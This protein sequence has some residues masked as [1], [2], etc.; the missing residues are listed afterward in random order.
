MQLTSNLSFK[1]ILIKSVLK[2]SLLNSFLSPETESN[3]I[4][5][6]LVSEKRVKMNLLNVKRNCSTCFNA[7]KGSIIWPKKERKERKEK[8]NTIAALRSSRQQSLQ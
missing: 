6:I 3:S 8:K 7:I 4:A 2:R 1:K 5:N